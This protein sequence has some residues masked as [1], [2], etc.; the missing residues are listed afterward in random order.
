MCVSLSVK[1]H[2]IRFCRHDPHGSASSEGLFPHHATMYKTSSRRYLL[3]LAEPDPIAYVGAK[4]FQEA[5]GI[6]LHQPIKLYDLPTW[7][8]SNS[9]RVKGV[10]RAGGNNQ[11][12]MVEY[13]PPTG[14]SSVTSPPFNHT[15]SR[16]GRLRGNAAEKSV[17][18]LFSPHTSACGLSACQRA[19]KSSG[20]SPRSTTP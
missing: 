13:Q 5:S 20:R 11:V 4:Q 6:L 14:R 1:G 10:F 18:G 19:T 2:C 3:S 15:L 17:R 12:P 9:K 7:A 16:S 8:R